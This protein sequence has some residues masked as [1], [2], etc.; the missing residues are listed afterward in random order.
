[1]RGVDLNA[2]ALAS[3]RESLH[4]SLCDGLLEL[5]GRRLVDDNGARG[6]LVRSSVA[7]ACGSLDWEFTGR[8]PQFGRGNSAE[9]GRDWQGN[10]VCAR[11][12]FLARPRYSTL[13]EPPQL[14][15][16]PKG[17]VRRARG[18]RTRRLIIAAFAQRPATGSPIDP[19]AH[20]Q[21][22]RNA[23]SSSFQYA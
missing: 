10:I 14:L 16:Y 7:V 15:D 18:S 6:P 1:V 3:I 21:L 19:V 12:R 22:S 8:T 17:R 11:A 5:K 4:R 9:T 20:S 23:R 13:G 2:C